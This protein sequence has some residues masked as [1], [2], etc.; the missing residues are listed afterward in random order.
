LVPL[1]NRQSN[2]S[3]LQGS[4]KES[5][6]TQ[7]IEAEQVKLLCLQ[8]PV[9]FVG[10]AVNAGIITF[11]LWPVTAHSL[12]IAWATVIG[13]ITVI[14]FI[15][16]WQFRRA[17]RTGGHQIEPW[18]TLLTL[19]YGFA[20]I[21]WGAVGILFFPQTSLAH[22]VFLAFLL[23]GMAAGAV[24][25]LSPVRAV[26]L[27]YVVPTL[28]PITVQLF[29]QGGSIPVAMGLLLMCFT[30]ALFTIAHYLHTLI[31]QSLRLRFENLDQLRQLSA[32]KEQAEAANQAKSQFV[33]NVSHELRTPMN[34]VLGVAEVL[35]Q[36]GLS[37]RQRPLVHTIYQAGQE[38]LRI[39]NDILDFSK[40][41]VGKL[42]LQEEAFDV[43]QMVEGVAALFRESAQ[44][45]GLE[46]RWVIHDGVPRV[47][48]GDYH[49]LRQVLANLV[50][51]ALKFTERGEIV[52]AVG[53]HEPHVQPPA[54]CLLYFSV[55]D[56]GIGIA[57]AARERIFES[58]SQ[59]DGSTTRR[60]GGTGLGL[61]IA[62]QLIRLMGGQ[63]GV[64]SEPGRGSTFWF[65]VGLES[66]PP[67]VQVEH[68]AVGLADPLPPLC[69]RVLLVEDNPINQGVMR[70]FLQTM[71]CH[72]E[73]AANGREALAMLARTSYDVVLMDCQMPEM[74]GFATTKTIREREAGWNAGHNTSQ[75]SGGHLPIIALT[76]SAMQGDRERCLAAGMDDYL[77]K[78]LR[79]N[80]LYAA[81]QRWL[82]SVPAG[83]GRPATRGLA[84]EVLVNPAVMP[85]VSLRAAGDRVSLQSPPSHTSLDYHVLN[86]L[87]TLRRTGEPDVFVQ[88]INNYLTRSPQLLHLM[89]EAI[90]RDDATTVQ[91][92]AHTLKSSS[93]TLGAQALAALCDDLEMLGS[94][95]NLGNAATLLS[96]ATAEYETV[97]TVLTAEIRKEGWGLNK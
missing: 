52:V 53:R 49:R 24:A 34:G 69:G 65:T 6:W 67:G 12:L 35:L 63:I 9:G 83:G 10:A 91:M 31:T 71:G 55:Q 73:M 32:A 60:Y 41:E 74:D 68:E 37:A 26:F 78:P 3:A 40:L 42:E 95:R 76:A 46:L 58:F 64:E 57:P 18:R 51:N 61:T 22:Q 86:Y 89:S 17:S 47:L 2:P 81:L 92:T 7:R 48:R 11:A 85:Q 79:Q 72:V 66:L 27:A 39:I 1:K 88:V 25:V 5:E 13:I 8:A 62:R 15:L 43:G 4:E 36:T 21:W 38:L 96:E 14:A 97:R 20:G 90:G 30:G 87:R 50:G 54:P 59:A 28:L 44:R 33:A 56:T 29:L 84:G 77:S 82:P 75:S 93:A 19:G 16:I 94:Q 80:Q 23:G 70:S 45:K